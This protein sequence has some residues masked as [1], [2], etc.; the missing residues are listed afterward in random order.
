MRFPKTHIAESVV[1]RI[2]NA[3]DEIKTFGTSM[4]GLAIPKEEPQVAS[5]ALEGAALDQQLM[6][7]PT[8]ADTDAAPAEEDMLTGVLGGDDLVSLL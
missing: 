6:E 5:P 2:L 8:G 3:H 1:N 7:S 4:G